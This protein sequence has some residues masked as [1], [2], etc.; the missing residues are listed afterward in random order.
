MIPRLNRFTRGNF[1]IPFCLGFVAAILSFS[2]SVW[3]DLVPRHFL[4]QHK[5]RR[6]LAVFFGD[7]ITQRGWNI[8]AHG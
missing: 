4:L 3:L 5:Q 2:A 7:S 6:K 1:A 8:E